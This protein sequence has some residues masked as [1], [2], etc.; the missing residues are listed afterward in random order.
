M[1]SENE[2][3]NKSRKFPI[4][5]TP[6]LVKIL[7]KDRT[8]NRNIIWASKN[9]MGFGL[10]FTPQSCIY[11]GWL[12]NGG[13]KLVQPRV[14]KQLKV[15]KERTKDK[16]EVYTPLWVVK[17]QN[18]LVEDEI[19]ALSLKKYVDYRWLEITCGEAPYMC[20]RYDATTGESLDIN[21]RVGFVDRKLQRISREVENHN[22]WVYF[23]FRAYQ[24]SFGYEFQGDSLLIAR[25]NLVYT[26]VDYYLDKFFELPNLSILKKIAEIIS[27]NVFQMD[28]LKYIIPYS[29]ETI[30]RQRDKQIS[31][32]PHDYGEE[33]QV[34][35]VI[36]GTKIR[37]K[38]WTNNKMITFE[39]LVKEEGEKMKFDVVI[40]NPP[41]QESTEGNNRD[42]PIYN[43]FMDEAYKIARIA[44]LITPA[45]FLF[46]A[47]QT[48]KNW[49]FKMLT[50]EHLKVFY[51]ESNSSKIF[52]TTDIKGGVAITYRDSDK[53]IGPVGTFIPNNIMETVVNRVY[54]INQKSLSN[55]HFNRSSYR[56]TET[57]YDVFPELIN[58]TKH[59]E[60]LTV[61]SNI[62]NKFPELFFD[63]KPKNVD[64]VYARIF[65]RIDNSRVYKWTDLTYIDQH[66]N[67]DKWKIYVAKS[68]GTGEFG[69]SLSAPEIGEPYTICTQTFISFGAFSSR[70]EALSLEKYLKTKFLRAL[71]GVK[72]ATPDNARKD[73]WKHVPLENFTSMSDIN[74]SK[75]VKSV[76]MQLYKKYGLS[77]EEID[78]IEAKVK[79]ME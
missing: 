78:F 56:L 79:K 7:L 11:E 14:K 65:G 32:F 38:N 24:A 73:V 49:N 9:Y 57:V 64:R 60:R 72:K 3:V 48:S 36:E 10:G 71:L 58:R 70:K 44:C 68:N 54:K 69:E 50:D 15:Q 31:L 25:E 13:S 45:R 62:F 17:I 55:I 8:S 4:R 12:T 23:A 37:L 29:Q 40:G 75:S 66:D 39:S 77:Q 26:F 43:Y 53:I 16:A 33:D 59:S 74:W 18:D 19:R 30:V 22:D 35:M 28:G 5:K 42:I 27:Y 47:G 41:Y 76:D 52:P 51:Y 21:D 1:K 61:G 67:L 20:T 46:N 6:K 63:E 34:Q 2:K